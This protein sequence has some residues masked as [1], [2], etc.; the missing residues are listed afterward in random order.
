[1]RQ[2]K[3]KTTDK[4]E[5][6][7]ENGQEKYTEYVTTESV[8]IK[9]E[10]K[11]DCVESVNATEVELP[12]RSLR[13]PR[14]SRG[15]TP[16]KLTR[17]RSQIPNES[18]DTVQNQEISAAGKLES[19]D[20]ANSD[21]KSLD[22]KSVSP[23]VKL[24]YME[25]QNLV[26]EELSLVKPDIHVIATTPSNIIQQ[27]LQMAL[28]ESRKSKPSIFIVQSLECKKDTGDNINSTIS[29][30]QMANNNNNNSLKK[31]LKS[32]SKFNRNDLKKVF[33]SH[34]GKKYPTC[35]RQLR[36]R[37]IIVIK[38]SKPK[39]KSLENLKD[40][41]RELRSSP[42]NVENQQ[43]LLE[44]ANKK[45]NNKQLN[46]ETK[47]YRTVHTETKDLENYVQQ[48]K[49]QTKTRLMAKASAL[50][51]RSRRMT[52][53]GTA[54]SSNLRP[55]QKSKLSLNKTRTHILKPRVINNKR[56]FNT[57]STKLLNSSTSLQQKTS[58]PLNIQNHQTSSTLIDIEN[59]VVSS[60]TNNYDERPS[61]HDHPTNTQSPITLG[62]LH[63][64]A[65]YIIASTPIQTKDQSTQFNSSSSAIRYLNS[66]PS[67][68][69]SMRNP[70]KLEY[71]VVLY[72]YHEVDILIVIQERLVSFWKCSKL[73]NILSS[74]PA[75]KPGCSHHTQHLHQHEIM[76]SQ[77]HSLGEN[78]C[79]SNIKQ[80]ASS[81]A[82]METN[83]CGEWILLGELRRL[84]YGKFF[85]N[86]IDDFY[87]NNW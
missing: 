11:T 71:G 57:S 67:A 55:K 53:R 10:E 41:K 50:L 63:N 48:H 39:Q 75:I 68:T 28:E 64:T 36:N 32:S 17:N 81:S 12:R 8:Q 7:S 23:V 43:K 49:T 80:P 3:L 9:K 13:S 2:A 77:K 58:L 83:V 86:Y 79:N 5:E 42:R 82:F 14:L 65:S 51:E 31:S 33:K 52:L 73:I 76:V 78:C 47:S 56:N 46:Q 85:L 30:E 27:K 37:K 19:L 45:V 84:N 4:S 21:L 54:P 24:E 26:D 25:K 72:I 15:K 87:K 6:K 35:K 66:L 1:M 34:K 69:Q 22:N 62:S 44:D 59:V 60:T 74:L 20:D 38:T 18:K 70:L 16:I 29:K 40:I 61:S